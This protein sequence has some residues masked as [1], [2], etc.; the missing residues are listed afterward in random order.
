ML[1]QIA[2][3]V[4]ALLHLIE[5]P[6][7]IK[8]RVD[9]SSGRKSGAL[10]ANSW[11]TKKESANLWLANKGYA[12]VEDRRVNCCDNDTSSWSKLD[13][14]LLEFWLS[15]CVMSSDFKLDPAKHHEQ[16]D[17][18][19]GFLNGKSPLGKKENLV[20]R[21]LD[22][23]LKQGN[24]SS[25]INVATNALG[26]ATSSRF[27]RGTQAEFSN[28]ANLHIYD[29]EMREHSFERKSGPLL[30]GL[31]YCISS[32]SMILLNKIVLSSYGFNAGISL[33][34]YQNFISVLVVL[35]LRL[36]GIV[37]TEKLT[38]KLVKVWIPVNLIFIGMLVTGMYSLKYINIAMVTILKNITNILTAIGE[39][40]I[41]KKH[42]SQKVWTAMF[43][44]IISAISGGV[45][46][47]SFNAVGY[48]WQ[49]LNCVLTASYSHERSVHWLFSRSVTVYNYEVHLNLIDELKLT[50]R[51][52]MDTAKQLTKSGSLNE[53]SMVL[54]NNALSLPFAIFLILLFGEWKYVY[55]VDVIRIPMFW[56]VATGSGFLG[57][58]I[59]FT[60]MWFLNQTGPTTYSLV[61]SLNKIPI[62]VAGLVLF[63]VQ[64]SL[65]NVFSI[66]FGLF[67]G[68]FFARAKMS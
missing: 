23:F 44:M 65:S 63:N 53:V 52:V 2:L 29:A 43:L 40:Y 58:S 30:S 42:Q 62:S 68:I 55:N 1:R 59:S 25:F 12:F 6:L 64:L 16:D 20:Y 18:E 38:W 4:G 45:T 28:D 24:R 47:I 46:D 48:V 26:R 13:L 22:G 34:F 19:F 3:D 8:V 50:L 7:A 61:G 11:L 5:S 39:L 51:R 37:T 60:S 32:C 21:F 33:M 15:L 57:L 36:F 35:L 14:H 66:L 10:P 9:R 17:S 49:L 56:V 41:F 67:A 27:L 54:L 31:A